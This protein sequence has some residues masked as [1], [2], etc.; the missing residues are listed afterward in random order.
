MPEASKNIRDQIPILI[1]G[2]GP[3]GL[4]LAADLGWRGIDCVVIEQGD[5]TIYHPRA[6][7]VNSRTMEFCRRWGIAPEVKESG[8]PPD[9]PPTIIYATSLP[10]YEV[11]RIE[12]PTHGGHAPL[13]TTPERS[14]RC[15]QIWF[16]PILRR[17]ASSFPSVLLRYNCRFESFERAGD[18][19][20][21]TVHNAASGQSE[22][23]AARYLID[24][25]GGHAGIG[26]TLGIK[27]E[28]RPVLSYHLN[29]F[30]NIKELWNRHDKGK[31]A[32]YFFVDKTGDY[33]SLIEIDG[34]ELWRIGVHGEAYHDEPSDEQVR[35][36]IAR[37]IGTNIPYD[38]ISARRWTC[39]DLVAD[40]FQ[41]PPIFL[42][43][44]SVHQHAPSGGFGMNTGMGDAVDLG[45]KLAG[46][47]AGWGGGGLLESYEAERRPV[48]QRNVGEA[49]DNVMRTTDP[50][51]IKLI[52]EPTAAGEAARRQIADDIV[53]NRAKTF[54]SDGIALGYRYE[55]PIVI[56][57]GTPAPRDSVMEYVQTSRPGS[58][59]PHAWLS[60]GKSTIDLFGR[61]FVLLRLGQDA[62]ETSGLVAAAKQRGLPLELVT[63]ADPKIAQLYE[64]SLVLVRPDGH[65][66]WRA[67]AAPEDPLAII[68][69]V[70]GS[71]VAKRAAR[72]A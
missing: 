56:P 30:L 27:Q 70:R 24:C 8:A 68:D 4:G 10:G 53:K 71:A 31:A 21:A 49:T 26:K 23:I 20:V 9:F 15:N 50:A 65:V 7:T 40:R 37:C 5:G 34:N 61:S 57:D 64:R 22:R 66:A 29:I 67:A 59:A 44:D 38:I 28:G 46:A 60:E 16:D 47:V 51:L 1:V 43:G 13:P 6:N 52:E 58:R 41:S 25:S 32:F 11:C 17:L 63:I 19:V 72:A 55:S 35:S 14:Q 33:G 18:G 39:R 3:V 69:T 45:W 62:P 42:A 48:A 2:G 54:I 36:V 12:R